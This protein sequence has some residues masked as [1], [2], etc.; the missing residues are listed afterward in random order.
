[1]TPSPSTGGP[2]KATERPPALIP[3]DEPMAEP[4]EAPPDKVV[5]RKSASVRANTSSVSGEFHSPPP[6][7]RDYFRGE[8][9]AAPRFP[10]CDLGLAPEEVDKLHG[11]DSAGRTLR[12]PRGGRDRTG[13]T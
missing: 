4:S 11:R 7:V 13:A 3:P 5:L 12:A 2:E 1:M 9:V 8:P 10:L 6:C